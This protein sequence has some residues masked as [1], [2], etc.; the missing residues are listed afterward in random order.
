MKAPKDYA[1]RDDAVGFEVNKNSYF[2]E[3]T[4]TTQTAADPQE[5]ENEKL[6]IPQTGGIGT[7]IFTVGGLALMGGAGYALRKSKKEEEEEA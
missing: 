6:T 1:L 5:I 7:I 2:N 4:E 3:P